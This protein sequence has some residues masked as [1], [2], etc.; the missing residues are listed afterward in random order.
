MEPSFKIS[1]DFPRFRLLGFRF[2]DFVWFSVIPS[3]RLLGCGDGYS[4]RIWGYFRRSVIPRFRLLVFG[5]VFRRSVIP[6]F[7]H[8]AVPSFR[9]LGSPPSH[10]LNSKTNDLVL[11]LKTIWRHWNSSLSP[12]ATDGTDGNGLKFE[13]NW[14]IF[15]SFDATCW[16]N[17]QEIYYG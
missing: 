14:P 10:Q 6:P 9:L 8:S 11:L 13:K 15:S 7:R 3:F 17:P 12:V 1:V 4:F 2:K 5:V 16:K